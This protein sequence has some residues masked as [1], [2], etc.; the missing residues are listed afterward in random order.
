[1]RKIILLLFLLTI[2]DPYSEIDCYECINVYQIGEKLSYQIKTYGPE[3]EAEAEETETVFSPKETL[4]FI[5]RMDRIINNP[6]DY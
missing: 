6:L 5:K 3:P 4:R 2:V 1:M